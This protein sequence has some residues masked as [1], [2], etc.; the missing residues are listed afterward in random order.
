MADFK[1]NILYPFVDG[2]WGGANQ[3]LKAVR[4]YFKIIG[5]YDEQIDNSDVI[6]F[7]S[8]PSSTF[9]KLV[10]ET[11]TIK[12]KYPD[13]LIINRIDGPVNVYRGKNK[14]IDKAFYLFT[15]HFCDGTIFQSN[16]SRDESYSDGMEK[17]SF[18][19]TVLN[20]PNPE[21][22][23]SHD[24]IELNKEEKIKLIATSWSS[25]WKKGFEVYKW[26][27]ENLDFTK[28]EMIFVGNTPIKFK[29]IIHK[30]P[31][32]SKGLSIELKKSHIFITA[33][34]SDP[35]SNSLIE[36]LHCGLPAIGLDDGGHTQII[37]KGGEVFINKEDIPN[38][39]EKILSDYEKYKQNIDLPSIDEVGKRYFEFI[40]G[41]HNEKI[42][43]NYIP[44]KVSYFDLL[45][46]NYYIY[47]WK[48]EE[49]LFAVKNK[50]FG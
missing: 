48:L 47:I 43:S 23:N 18:E 17:N 40:Q 22:F 7:N 15:K 42:S 46:I 2:P 27:D 30:E 21:I 41:I 50:V 4:N 38:L 36:A 37:S 13:K 9:H 49:K 8:S 10:K 5:S 35:C 32:D 3:F 33:S 16:W 19:T 26:L 25:N 1:I 11:Y 29:N 12:Q 44:K 28:Y 20:A 31:V 6:L 24:T 45:K 39:L 34:Q 14:S